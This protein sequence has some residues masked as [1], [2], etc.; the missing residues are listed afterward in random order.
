MVEAHRAPSTTPTH[1]HHL[2]AV[3][4]LCRSAHHAHTAV[5]IPSDNAV[6]PI[7]VTPGGLAGSRLITYPK[8]VKAT[9]PH[10]A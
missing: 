2:A 7:A 6:Q 9:S 4:L 1:L 5:R 10:H 8:A 3:A